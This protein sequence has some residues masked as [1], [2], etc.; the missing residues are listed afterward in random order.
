MGAVACYD[1]SGNS[2]DCSTAGSSSSCF[3]DLG[4][5]TIQEVDCSS[6]SAVA[7]TGP[8]VSSPTLTGALSANSSQTGGGTVHSVTSPGTSTTNAELQAVSAL[9]TL[10]TTAYVASQQPSPPQ[11][12]VTASGLTLPSTSMTTILLIV[13]AVI[14]AFFAFG[15]RKKT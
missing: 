1:A 11:R 3:G 10:G 5:G 9:A 15:G 2:I 12:T 13:V 7:L 6:Y 14:V 8:A 4:D